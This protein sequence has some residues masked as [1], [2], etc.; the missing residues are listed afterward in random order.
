MLR[1]PGVA[2]RLRTSSFSRVKIAP[3]SASSLRR[4]SGITGF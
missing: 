3:I 4:S 1:V 2:G